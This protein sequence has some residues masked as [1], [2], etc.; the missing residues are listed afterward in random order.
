MPTLLRIP[1]I[2]HVL[3]FYWRLR[4]VNAIYCHSELTVG[5]WV[6]YA[7]PWL[8]D[9]IEGPVVDTCGRWVRVRNSHRDPDTD[10]SQHTYH[11][12]PAR[13]CRPDYGYGY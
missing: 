5:T 7:G 1:G 2:R 3:R 8:N 11:W 10:E 12:C 6:R 13:D 9:W 4:G